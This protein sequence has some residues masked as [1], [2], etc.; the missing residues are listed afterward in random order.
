MWIFSKIKKSLEP[1]IT[2]NGPQYS[3]IWTNLT[4][5]SVCISYIKQNRCF[6][7]FF[8]A[9]VTLVLVHGD[10]SM[11]CM[12]G[13]NINQPHSWFWCFSKFSR[14]IFSLAKYLSKIMDMLL[15]KET[16]I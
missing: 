2:Y 11:Q 1:H 3:L 6:I 7:Y 15:N 10:I 5:D 14:D 8:S 13:F 4:K 16:S 9:F 12:H